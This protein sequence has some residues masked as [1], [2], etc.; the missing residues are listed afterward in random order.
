MR[1]NAS[2]TAAAIA[3]LATLGPTSTTHAA[4]RNESFVV[5]AGQEKYVGDVPIFGQACFK[6]VSRA[7][8]AP[9]RAHF[10]GLING[11]P[12]DLDYHHGG[13][14]LK[15]VRDGGFGLY[16]VYVIAEGE[17]LVVIRSVEEKPHDWRPPMNPHFA[18]PT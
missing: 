12:I 15:F 4:T 7:T 17:D 6:V 5:P 2:L 18:P 13:R 3:T 10:R 9:A 11:R 1:F 14:C 16:R 8:N